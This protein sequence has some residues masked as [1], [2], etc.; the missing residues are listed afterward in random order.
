M[1]ILGALVMGVVLYCS[2]GLDDLLNM[3]VRFHSARKENYIRVYLANLVGVVLIVCIAGICAY[4]ARQLSAVN[5]LRQLSGIVLAIIAFM[6]FEKV[7]KGDFDNVQGEE[8][9]VETFFKALGMYL[10]NAIDDYAANLSWISAH[11]DGELFGALMLGNIFGMSL[12]ALVAWRVSPVFATNTNTKRV[13]Y[14]V[15]AIALFVLAAIS[16]R[17]GI[18]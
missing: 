11:S 7:R 5:E 2:T 10:L 1:E 3:T 17:G 16:L 18:A 15:A 6:Y 13:L 14:G 4:F 8:S 9:G 12:Y